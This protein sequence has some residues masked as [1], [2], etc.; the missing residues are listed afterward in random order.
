MRV[1]V[2]VCVCVSIMASHAPRPEYYVKRSSK[3]PSTSMCSRFPY[4][5]TLSNTLLLCKKH[6]SQPNAVASAKYNLEDL[7]NHFKVEVPSPDPNFSNHS[8]SAACCKQIL[9]SIFKDKKIE[10]LEIVIEQN[11]PNL[12]TSSV[13]DVLCSL[14]QIPD[15]FVQV[16]HDVTALMVVKIHSSPYEDTI[17]KT[18]LVTA[19]LLRLRRMYDEHI[20]KLTGFAFPKLGKQQ[21]VVKVVVTWRNF[22][23]NYELLPLEIGEV[24]TE[25]CSVEFAALQNQ[26]ACKEMLVIKLSTRDLQQIGEGAIQMPSYYAIM[27]KSGN[28]VYKAP[29]IKKH[30][31][32]LDTV[33]IKEHALTLREVVRGVTCAIQLEMT[34]I[35]KT[36][37]FRMNMY[38]TITWRLQKPNDALETF[39]QKFHV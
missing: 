39:L 29:V 13:S 18:L 8:R 21:C 6:S 35:D 30:A 15:L 14:D 12:K 3:S 38:T 16:Q 32:T 19:D 11:I 4:A 20:D 7:C 36:P 17:Q 27:V 9:E 33:V 31:L 22:V 1:C 10:N 2:C 25:I 23:L 34:I 26:N 24:T 28:R 5:I 37:F